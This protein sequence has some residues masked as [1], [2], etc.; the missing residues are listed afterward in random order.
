MQ[1]IL[2]LHAVPFT[3]TTSLLPPPPPSHSRFPHLVS[4]QLYTVVDVTYHNEVLEGHCLM[5]V[6]VSVN[7]GHTHKVL[8]VLEMPHEYLQG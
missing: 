2:R 4:E 7:E 6:E 8:I 1:R 5:D 3:A